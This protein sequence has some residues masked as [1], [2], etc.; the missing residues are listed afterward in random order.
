[1]TLPK[2][3]A[4]CPTYGRPKRLLDEVV[5]CFLQQDYEGEKELVIFNDWEKQTI[6]FNHPQVKIINSLH[7]IE[8]L[9]K[10]FNTAIS[11]CTGDIIMPWESDDLFL[12]HR[13]TMSVEKMQNGFFHS[14]NAWFFDN[15]T[16]NIEAMGN[17]CLCNLAARREH[18]ENVG[19]FDERGVASI[20]TVL[21]QAMRE[22]SGVESIELAQEEAFYVYRWNTGSYHASGWGGDNPEMGNMVGTAVENEAKCGKVETGLI[23]LEPQWYQ[24]YQSYIDG[25]LDNNRK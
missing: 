9:G 21:I 10:V 17:W 8:P 20:D 7:R 5:H 16:H 25:W 3:S 18:W 4:Y 13:M 11:H 15:V 14:S 22:S 19:Y 12:P 1:M 24:P 6:V 23:M 2:I